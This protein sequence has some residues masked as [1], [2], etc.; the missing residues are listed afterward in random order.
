VGQHRALGHAGGP[1][2]VLQE[3]E[4]VVAERRLVEAAATAGSERLPEADGA[5]DPPLRNTRWMGCKILMPSPSSTKAP[6]EK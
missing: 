2:G 6:S 5:V 4:V 3:R 1:A